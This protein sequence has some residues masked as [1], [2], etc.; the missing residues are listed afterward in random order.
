[1]MSISGNAAVTQCHQ[2][3]CS[4]R[5]PFIGFSSLL[6]MQSYCTDIITQHVCLMGTLKACL[7]TLAFSLMFR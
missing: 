4:L 6:P 2:Y 3:Y 7:K 5:L 1:M